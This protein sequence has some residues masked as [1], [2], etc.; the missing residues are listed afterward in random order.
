VIV[1]LLPEASRIQD[2]ED[3]RRYVRSAI[4][5]CG[6][7]ALLFLPI[8]V[9]IGPIT[10]LL[11]GGKY[12]EVPGLFRIVFWGSFATLLVHPLY[13]VLYAR[14]K[15]GLVTLVN[16]VQAAVCLGACW[17]LI[18]RLGI[19]GAA[20]GSLTARLCGC[21]LIVVAVGRELRALRVSP[22]SR[23]AEIR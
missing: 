15:P 6:A 4:R 20:V 8:L 12:P 21:A 22:G 18:P 19:T 16:L 3:L 13:L 10:A 17:L 1:S 9:T 7:L 2:R 11:Y 23:L 5:Q 14:N